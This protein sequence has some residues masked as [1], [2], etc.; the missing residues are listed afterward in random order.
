MQL[1]LIYWGVSSSIHMKIFLSCST[2]A[3]SNT[4]SNPLFSLLNIG[5]QRFSSTFKNQN[6]LLLVFKIHFKFLHK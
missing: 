4:M 6:S 3:L 2:A 5:C 1:Q